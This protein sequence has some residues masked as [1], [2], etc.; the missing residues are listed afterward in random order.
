[1]KHSSRKASKISKLLFSS[2]QPLAKVLAQ[3][4]SIKIIG[5][6][7]VRKK[8]GTISTIQKVFEEIQMNRQ[9][10]IG[11]YRIDVLAIECNKH[12]HKN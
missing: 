4:M 8:A 10:S 11:S 9:F 7:Y 3:Y 2:Q 5:Y 1:M 12:D 6:K